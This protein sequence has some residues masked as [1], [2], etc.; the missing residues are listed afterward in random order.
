[1][2]GVLPC[3]KQGL[4]PLVLLQD[5]EQVHELTYAEPLAG[6]VAHGGQAS[7]HQMTVSSGQSSQC[8]PWQIAL[9]LLA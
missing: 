8:L 6:G 9:S 3:V 1:M 4:V 7:G 5:N 2:G